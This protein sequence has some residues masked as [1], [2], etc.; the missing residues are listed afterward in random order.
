MTI[1]SHDVD[2]LRRCV[3]LARAALTAG[4]QPFGS[5]LVSATGAVLFED[6]NRVAGGDTTRHPEFE[7]CRWAVAHL[8]PAD[9][10]AATV[11]TSG[12]HCPMC[13]AAHGWVGLGRIVFATSTGQLTGWLREWGAPPGPVAALPIEQVVPGVVAEG[14][15]REFEPEM[16]ALYQ[17]CFAPDGHAPA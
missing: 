3:E 8:S 16:R 13:S 12:E 4:D 2:H 5:L 6:R 1:S 15:V 14:P 7:I 10:A 11:Y 17:R 9:R